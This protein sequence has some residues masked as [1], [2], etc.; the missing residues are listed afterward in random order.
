MS[1]F[2]PTFL[3]GGHGDDRWSDGFQCHQTGVFVRSNTPPGEPDEGGIVV[4]FVTDFCL[5]I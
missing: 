3:Q 2:K 4:S 5:E 1:E